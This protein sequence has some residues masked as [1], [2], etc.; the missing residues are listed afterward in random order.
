MLYKI[1]WRIKTKPN[2]DTVHKI[3][4][5]FTPVSLEGWNLIVFSW[6]ITVA[7][8]FVSKPYIDLLQSTLKFLHLFC[9]FFV[10]KAE[11]FSDM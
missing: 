1:H 4:T 2:Y 11:K 6:S 3:K 10:F 9:L 5:P 7:L 8:S